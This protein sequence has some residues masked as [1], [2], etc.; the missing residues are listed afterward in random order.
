MAGLEQLVQM[1]YHERQQEG[2]NLCAQHALNSLLQGNYFTAP[3]LSEFARK[4]DA[5]E[6]YSRYDDATRARTSTNMD[7]TGFFSVQV[8]EEALNVWNLS[9]VRWRSEAMKPYQNEPHNQTAFVLNQNQHWYTLRRFGDLSIPGDGHWFN[10]DSTKRQP[11]WISKLYLGM[12]LQQAESD[13]YSIFTVTQ[14]DPDAHSQIPHVD[15]DAI[16]ST[17]PDPTSTSS[18][19][20][21][22][23]EL[24]FENEDME[25]QAALQASLVGSGEVGSSRAMPGFYPPAHARLSADIRGSSS[26]SS[27]RR[28][29]PGI[30][31]NQDP[32]GNADVD[33]IT[34]S[35]ER[36]RVLMERMRREQEF[37]FRQQY[38]EEAA[39]FGSRQPPY[40][41]QA[42]GSHEDEH[43]RRAITDSLAERHARGDIDDD[44]SEDS[45]YVP[46]PEARTSYGTGQQDRVYDD[47]DAN[48]QAALRA[49]LESAPPEF[50]PLPVQPLRARQS[51]PS[52]HIAATFEDSE[53]DG[54][55]EA[56]TSTIA[57]E[58]EAPEEAVSVEEMRRRRLARFGG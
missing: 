46:T 23:A 10:L 39:R 35:M 37:G 44:D 19:P 6:E 7:D 5:L 47:D 36:D 16:A 30:P 18:T 12:F 55:S 41:P 25:L 14:I 1:I 51:P 8:L 43:F 15:A 22:D 56:D 2:S 27:A 42:Q 58:S 45:D 24:G 4:M 32:Y 54:R 20:Q 31:P 17:L 21:D 33:P 49:S 50:I 11:Q 48:F 52:P 38:E 57:S 26:S 29:M 34:A 13:G 9:L 28:A 53:I 40:G 3:D